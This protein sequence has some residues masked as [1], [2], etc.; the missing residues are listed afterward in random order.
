MKLILFAALLLF[1]PYS[2]SIYDF[3]IEGLDNTQIDFSKF[4]GKK[5][6]IVNVA[7]YCGYTY[8]YEGLEKLYQ[9][10]KDKLVVVGFPA[11]NF[12]NQEPESNEKIQEFCRKDK[13]V[14]FPI[15]K[16]ISVAGDDI[17]PIFK[18]LI[19]EAEKSGAELPV[20]KWNFTKF[21]VDEN[22]KLLKVFRSKVEPM[23]EEITAFLK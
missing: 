1:A 13:G 8:Q 20:I 21:L 10:Y 9:T 3:K 23:S 7:S 11:N 22:G 16:K 6:L 2:P 19:Q 17:H 14:Q 15:A 4:K 5:I 12:K 18:Y